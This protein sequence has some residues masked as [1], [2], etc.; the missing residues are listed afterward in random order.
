MTS[1][2]RNIG[3][4]SLGLNTQSN[5]NLSLYEDAGLVLSPVILGIDA[6][7]SYSH[8]FDYQTDYCLFLPLRAY[9]DIAFTGEERPVYDN[10][11]GLKLFGG[12]SAV[13]SDY[14][15][16][17]PVLGGGADLYLGQ[18]QSE[19]E[20]A[21]F[22]R[23]QA[24]GGALGALNVGSEGADPYETIYDGIDIV[25][26]L[27]QLGLNFYKQVDLSF[28]AIIGELFRPDDYWDI[29]WGNTIEGPDA[30]DEFYG[31]SARFQLKIQS[32]RLRLAYY[33]LNRTGGGYY[34]IVDQLGFGD[35][36]DSTENS[37]HR[38]TGNA[39]YRVLDED[40]LELDLGVR[41]N[42]YA[43]DKTTNVTV[44]PPDEA[45]F[46]STS[47]WNNDRSYFNAYASLTWDLWFIEVGGGYM[48][49]NRAYELGC[50]PY[51]DFPGDESSSSD[52]NLYL[53]T[54]LRW[55]GPGGM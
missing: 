41:G 10:R 52:W 22:G 21:F 8:S 53:K 36:D 19:D 40:D 13:A 47:S 26:G 39:S 34:D 31:F 28:E 5:L 54:A 17:F 24:Q 2:T 35:I 25:S 48:E 27:A 12:A 20:L 51:C 3:G 45:D 49:G 16:S 44:H 7:A 6:D 33:F 4:F 55:G 9:I 15:N 14:G 29:D 50:G 42:Y 23:L 1:E 30:Y 46:F 38:L 43:S 32:F 37:S 11:N 18:E